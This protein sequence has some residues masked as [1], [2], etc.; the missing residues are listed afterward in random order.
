MFILIFNFF[1]EGFTQK[2][3]FCHHS[4]VNIPQPRMHRLMISE[5]MRVQML[6]NF[7]VLKAVL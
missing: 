7:T 6:S 2:L 3:K 5:I 4:L 1:V